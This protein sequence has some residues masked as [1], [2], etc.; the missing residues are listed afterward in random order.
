M[1][2]MT[3]LLGSLILMAMLAPGVATAQNANSAN[4]RSAKT[5]KAKTPRTAPPTSDA[6]IQ[7]CIQD[8]LAASAKLKDQGFSVS[9]SNGEATF[10]GTARNGGSKGAATRMAKSCGAKKVTNNITV[11]ASTKPP[12]TRKPKKT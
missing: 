7:K 12:K 1:K 9:V 2:K 6:D 10:T 11:Q 3:A 4:A 8:K 5:R